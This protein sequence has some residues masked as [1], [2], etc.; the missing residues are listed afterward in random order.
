MVVFWVILKPAGWPARPLLPSFFSAAL[1]VLTREFCRQKPLLAPGWVRWGGI[2]LV[3]GSCEG[4][5]PKRGPGISS[6]GL[7]VLMI[8]F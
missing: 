8:V 5:I 6:A 7:W 3:F 4:P 1:L 2:G